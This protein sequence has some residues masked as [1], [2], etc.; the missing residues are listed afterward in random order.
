MDVTIPCVCLL[1]AAIHL[2]RSIPF[3]PTVGELSFHTHTEVNNHV[4]LRTSPDRLKSFVLL[5]LQS[6]LN[7]STCAV[8]SLTHDCFRQ[9]LWW[10]KMM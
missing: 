8:K 7:S 6:Q 10:C 9:I 4:A 1:Q 5:S 2:N 3:L